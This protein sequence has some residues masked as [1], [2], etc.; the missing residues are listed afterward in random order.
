VDY[1]MPNYGDF[2]HITATLGKLAEAGLPVILI[3]GD[4]H[5]GRVAGIRDARTGRESIF[6]IISS[7]TS[8]ASSVG[9][10]Q[11][12]AVRH[13]VTGQTNAWPR[14]SPRAPVPDFLCLA[15]LGDASAAPGPTS[16]MAIM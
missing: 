13:A 1:L 2:A 4:V 10:D 12:V 16:K 3:T 5:W 11:L 9:K 15:G 6:E 8:L 14:H 7:P